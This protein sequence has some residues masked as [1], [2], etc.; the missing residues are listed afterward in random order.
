MS[1]MCLFHLQQT[2]EGHRHSNGPSLLRLSYLTIISIGVFSIVFVNQV[3]TEVKVRVIRTAV[4][5]EH[6]YHWVL[7]L[8]VDG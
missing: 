3:G 6:R 2:K 1:T 7:L 5:S 4:T 8:Y